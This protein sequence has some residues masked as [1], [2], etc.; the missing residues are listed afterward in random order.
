MKTYQIIGLSITGVAV[1]TLALSTLLKS[2]NN[3]SLSN[4]NL[5]STSRALSTWDFRSKLEYTKLKDGSEEMIHIT[6]RR[7]TLYQNLDGDNTIDR[8][9]KE[10]YV[11][12]DIFKLENILLRRYDYGTNSAGFNSADSL[13]IAE[14]ERNIP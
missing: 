7:I 13:L 10:K 1:L 6:G 14:R 8:I 9:R 12:R 5:T 2:C 11:I 3:Y 4:R